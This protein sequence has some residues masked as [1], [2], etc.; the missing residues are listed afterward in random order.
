MKEPRTGSKRFISLRASRVVFARAD[1]AGSDG[2]GTETAYFPCAAPEIHGR[3]RSKRNLAPLTASPGTDR[4]QIPRVRGDF[5]GIRS[6]REE[7]ANAN[8]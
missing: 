2:S 5:L 3:Q 4:F 1:V 7:S 8:D 6:V